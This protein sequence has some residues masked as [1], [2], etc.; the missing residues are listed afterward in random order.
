MSDRIRVLV[1]DDDPLL[2]A[3][4]MQIV[5]PQGYDCAEA[6]DGEDAV[7]HLETARA[8]LVVLDMLMPNKEGVE[9]IQELR[10]RWPEIRI[11][12]ISGG[13]A[14]IEPDPLLRMAALMGADAVMAKPLYAKAFLALIREV[15]AR[16]R[17]I[18]AAFGSSA[19]T[20]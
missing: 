1:V 15:M 14:R 19:R 20:G 9:T 13:A 4:V 16:P 7:T 12:A 2:R 3:I 8:D 10:A 11:I 17:V 6:E 18:T 5:V